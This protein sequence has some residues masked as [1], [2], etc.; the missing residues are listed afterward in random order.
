M[1]MKDHRRH[2]L[3]SDDG[4]THDVL[5]LRPEH[6]AVGVALCGHAMMSDRRTLYRPGRPSLGA[7]LRDRRFVVL[8]P[9][10]RGHGHSGPGAAEG[11]SWSYDQLVDDVGLYLRHARE[12]APGLPLVVI[13]HSLFGGLLLAHLGRA[14]DPGIEGAATLASYVQNPR[15]APRWRGLAYRASIELFAFL[16]R[17][18]G[19]VAARRFRAGSADEPLEL[20]S[21]LVRF[22]REGRLLSRDGFDYHDGFRNVSCPVLHIVSAAD[23]W[24]AP[25]REAVA[26]VSPLPRCELIVAGSASA[27][28][29]FDRLAPSHMGIVLDPRA[30]PIWDEVAAWAQRTIA[31]RGEPQRQAASG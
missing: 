12:V 20:W 23:H 6:P 7:T 24:Y 14:P 4:W 26:F 8:M 11:G 29:P 5:E 18:I 9:D 17:R 2:R 22:V 3:T 28:A 31:E 13:G 30:Q 10:L 25:A 19:H 15:F 27:A 21:D 1:D 16:S